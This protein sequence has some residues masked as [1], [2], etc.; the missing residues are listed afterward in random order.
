MSVWFAIGIAWL[1][2]ALLMSALWYVQYRRH[3]AG[4]VD[5]AWSFGTGL[6]AVF[7]ALTASGDPWRKVLVAVIAGVWGLRLGSA[8]AVRVLSEQ[9]DGRYQM[10]REKWGERVQPLMFGFFQIQ[11]AWAVLFAL[12]MLAA[13]YNPSPVRA[14]DLFAIAVWLVAVIGESIADLQLANFKKNPENKGKVCREG[15]WAW[16][17][18]PNYFFEWV[19]WFAYLILAI[20]GSLLWLAALGPVVMLLFLTKVTGIPMT[21]ARSIKSRGE[22]YR[23]YQRTVSP[24]FPWPPKDEQ[25]DSK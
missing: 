23:E 5:I 11:A 22:A 7:F 25:G 18:H 1:T 21:E 19:H 3:N 20:G 6:C 10:L 13:S 8:L 15:L 14:L 12:P 9:E 4:I 2:M 17:R 16:S 24:F